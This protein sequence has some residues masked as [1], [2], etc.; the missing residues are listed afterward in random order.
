[1]A[2]C[3]GLAAGAP[4]LYEQVAC[5]VLSEVRDPGQA[6]P[7]HCLFRNISTMLPFPEHFDD[8]AFSGHTLPGLFFWTAQMRCWGMRAWCAAPAAA[9]QTPRNRARAPPGQDIQQRRW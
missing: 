1:M 4:L 9:M 5:E 7:E 2:A 6:G 8:V 3:V